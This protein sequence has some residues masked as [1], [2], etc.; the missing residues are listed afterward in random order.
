MVGF[1]FK[2]EDGLG[3]MRGGGGQIEVA[4]LI[5]T[6]GKVVRV[7]RQ[8]PTSVLAFTAA[9]ELGHAVLHPTLGAL[10]RDKPLDGSPTVGDRAEIEANKFAA[11]FLMP[12]RLVRARFAELFQAERFD[13]NDE[14]A[15]ALARSPVPCGWQ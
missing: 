10:H 12:A 7:G 2:V 9:H 6:R 11:L 4:G 15:F 1:D 5:D 8:F 13:L 14:T 3:L